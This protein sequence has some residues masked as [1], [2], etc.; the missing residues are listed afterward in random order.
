MWVDKNDP[1]RLSSANPQIPGAQTLKE[2]VDFIRFVNPGDL[3]ASWVACYACHSDAVEKCSTNIMATGSMLWEAAFYNNGSTYKKNA[4]YGEAYAL[5]GKPAHVVAPDPPTPEQTRTHGWLSELWPLSRWEVSQPGNILRV[6]E[7]GGMIPK[8]IGIPDPEEDAGHPDV[9]LSIRGLGTELR[10]DPVNIGLQKTRLLDPTLNL[11]GT[12]DHPGDYRASGCS[13]CHVVYANDRSPVHSGVWAQYGNKGKSFSADGALIDKKSESGHPIQHY[14]VQQMPTSTC[15]VCHIHPGT[16]VVNSYTGYMWWDNETD[17][18]SMYPKGERAVTELDE[19]N[20]NQHNPEQASVRGF[21][22]DLGQYAT[23]PE[24]KAY[25]RSEQ[26]HFGH[27]AGDDFLASLYDKNTDSSFDSGLKHTHFSDYHG[28]GWV[29]RA[30]YKKDRKGDLLDEDG[31][32]IESVTR[33]EL[34]S[35]AEYTQQRDAKNVITNPKA[36]GTPVHLK[37]IHLEMGMQCIDCHL[38][39]DNHGDGHL[40]GATRDAVQEDCIDCHGTAESPAVLMEYMKDV[41]DGS[42][43]P[44]KDAKD[45]LTKAQKA[46]DT[47]KKLDPS[48]PD[49]AGKIAAAQAKVDQAQRKADRFQ[50]VWSGNAASGPP[51]RY[52]L[53]H[54]DFRGGKLIQKSMT[55]QTDPAEAQKLNLPKEWVVV[56]TQ[57]T[58]NPKSDWAKGPASR[59][60]YGDNG[61]AI[62][63]HVELASYAHSVRR[64]GTWGEAPNPLDTNL[65]E[66]KQLAHG[67]NSVSC[68]AC[69]TSWNTSCFGCH[70][71]QRAN[72]KKTMQHNEG[73]ETRNYTNYNYQ[74]LRD[75]MYMLGKDSTTKGGKVVP[76]RSAC[77]VMVSSQNANRDWI[78]VQQQTVSAEGFAGTAFSPYFPHTVRATETRQC[79][80]CHL[81]KDEDGHNDNNAVMSQ[82]LMQGLNAYNF[83]GR[84]AWV[85]CGD[86]G[87]HAVAVTERDEPQAVIGSRLHEYAYPDR[88]K[89]HVSN[90]L[91]LAESYE[92]EGDV[93]DVQQRGEYLYAACGSHGFIAYDIANIDNKDFSERFSLAPVSPLGQRFYVDSKDAT[94]IC[95]PSVMA[96]DPTRP[97]F[98]ENEEQSINL[99]FAFLYLTDA[100]EGLIVIGNPVDTPLG[101]RDHPTSPGPGVATL[102][103]GNPENNFLQRAYTFNPGGQ[104]RGARHAAFYGHYLFVSC[105]NGIVVIDMVDVLHP[106]IVTTLS[107]G[108]RHPKKVQF[109]FRYGFVVDDEGLK[110]FDVQ[111]LLGL[112]KPAADGQLIRATYPIADARDVYLSRTY[113]YVAAGKEG[114]MIFDIEKPEWPNRTDIFKVDAATGIKLDDCCA[115]KIGMTNASMYA[116]VADGKNGLRVLQLTSSDDRDVNGDTFEFLGFSPPPHPR[117][118]SWYKTPGRAIAVGEGLYRDR[119]VDESGH[120]LGVFGRRGARPFTLAEQQKLYLTGDG[121]PWYVTNEAPKDKHAYEPEATRFNSPWVWKKPAPATAPTAK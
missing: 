8:E 12:N 58:I 78:Y 59:P 9:K 106:K 36:P 86:E 71:D 47:A 79:A 110:V 20:V 10:T 3:R 50:H 95:T 48:K 82:L 70:L 108:I 18:K 102:L 80:D 120:Q 98:K 73:I 55:W 99:M 44:L 67:A 64:D 113:A 14:F 41:K 31:K 121:T 40:Y 1:N 53:G 87:V 27:Y 101:T 26:D 116:Y 96:L 72:W 22:S 112:A 90:G 16:N 2:S 38:E 30:I 94:S 62:G 23:T 69:H 85:A 56:Q 111:A 24:A 103:D 92:H 76:V 119:A 37:D 115:V 51:S 75:D 74:T 17:G 109:Q 114:L 46:L 45:D 4:I 57:D 39:Q 33:A 60:S 100:E 32:V 63:T 77:A 35:A 52:D 117:L 21:W 66:S 65:S 84:F 5:D 28:H 88:F 15:I 7:R 89:K 68:Y 105:E 11:F 49:T 104:L 54:F 97:H 29:F 118:V 34:N 107:Q 13:A 83:I 42:K 25:Y 19:F 93:R 91:E 6:F 81:H 61:Q 43:D